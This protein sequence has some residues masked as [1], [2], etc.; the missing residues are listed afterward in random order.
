MYS[1]TLIENNLE[2]AS[3]QIR[4]ANKLP[5]SWH[6]KGSSD[7]ERREMTQLFASLRDRRGKL[8]RPL[9]REE[10]LW[11]YCEATLCKID[12]HYFC[13]YALIEDWAGLIVPFK[14]NL[15]QRLV[16]DVMAEQ[17]DRRLAQA[18]MF[19]KARQLGMTTLWQVLLAHRVFN[20]RNVNCATGSAE[21]D[22]SRAM[23]G[24]LEFLWSQ[25]PWWLQPERTAYRAGELIEYGH[26]NSTINVAWGNQK[27]GIGRG[28]TAQ[29]VHLSELASFLDPGNLVDASLMRTI[30]EN[31][32]S[33]LAL[34]STAGGS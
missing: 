15:A 30:H 7:T 18:Y 6:L 13:N 5:R 26:Q 29:V 1:R 16:L 14:P 10:Q 25:L 12:F 27:Q 19:L 9:T 22:K 8:V 4:R 11:Q 21:P 23:V 31:P 24:K 34:E 3:D 32:F 17:E 33:L 2:L 20:Y 28:N